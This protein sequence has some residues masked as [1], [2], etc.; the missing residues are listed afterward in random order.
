L[1]HLLLVA[2][3]AARFVGRKAQALQVTQGDGDDFGVIA[4]T[5]RCQL[6]PHLPERCTFY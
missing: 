2:D 1:P 5:I 6:Y 3:A 4:Q